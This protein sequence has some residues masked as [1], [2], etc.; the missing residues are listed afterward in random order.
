MAQGRKVRRGPRHGARRF[1]REKLQKFKKLPRLIEASILGAGRRIK[2]RF[3][4]PHNH[5]FAKHVHEKVRRLSKSGRRAIRSS[6]SSQQTL[7]DDEGVATEEEESSDDED[8]VDDERE[9]SIH[10]GESSSGS[11]KL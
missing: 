9:L 11:I 7:L 10:H 6:S 8:Y 1:A 5:R 4:K 3:P 2:R